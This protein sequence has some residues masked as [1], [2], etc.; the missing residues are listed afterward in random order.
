MPRGN[1]GKFYTQKIANFV[2]RVFVCSYPT[3]VYLLVFYIL[4]ALNFIKISFVSVF[5]SL[6]RICKFSGIWIRKVIIC[7]DPNPSNNEQKV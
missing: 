5:R 3:L 6:I 1:T 7:T 4:F 2:L